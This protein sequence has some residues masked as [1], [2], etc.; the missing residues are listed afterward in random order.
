MAVK[1]RIPTPLQKLTDNTGEVHCDAKNINEMLSALEKKHPGIKERLCDGDGKLRRF[2]N[3]YVNEEDIRFLQGQETA[4]KDGDDISIIPAIAGGAA[5]SKRSKKV[6]RWV[7]ASFV[8][9]GGKSAIITK[10]VTLVFPQDQIKEPAVFLMAKKFDITPNIRRAR[11]TETVGEML[12]ELQGSE[13]NLR[14]GIQFLEARGIKV[15]PVT[16]E[17]A[18]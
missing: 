12:L 14:D 11:V 9:R 2:V 18:L 8:A 17:S 16:G 6:K 15:E 1:V 3:I 4:I 13:K 10:R 7:K 5:L